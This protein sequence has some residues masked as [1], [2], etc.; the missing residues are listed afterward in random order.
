[1][2]AALRRPALALLLA[3]GAAF[4]PRAAQPAAVLAAPVQAP[5]YEA[6]AGDY[7]RPG[8]DGAKADLAILLWLQRT[9]TADDV[10]R[11][12]S[13]V[14]PDLAL[15]AQVTG[16]SLDA[17]RFPLTRALCAEAQEAV[18]QENG[19]LKGHFAR[20]RPYA[21]WPEVHPAVR[22]EPSFAYPSGHSGWGVASAGVL[23][24]LEP[25]RRQAILERGL[26]V[27]FDRV[28]A[29]VH[30]P[31]DVEAGQRV[32]LAVTGAW[33]AAP[34]HRRRLEAARAAEW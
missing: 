10:R 19:R 15:F 29:G 25:G 34:E 14:A 33:L 17:A 20:P 13:E 18:R 32:A 12:E 7:P 24:L 21:T 30:H 9:R 1:M 6:L 26:L 5:D 22:L 4:A 31:S 8:S 23:A 11:A 3:L 27:G 2:A 28:L 16:R